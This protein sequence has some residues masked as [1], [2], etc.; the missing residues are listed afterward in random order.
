M[1]AWYLGNASASGSCATYP[2]YPTLRDTFGLAGALVAGSFLR[3]LLEL[4]LLYVSPVGPRVAVIALLLGVVGSV[5]LSAAPLCLYFA[6][7]G[8]VTS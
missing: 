7:P 1:T 6:L 4:G 8:A 5:L 3:Y 2:A